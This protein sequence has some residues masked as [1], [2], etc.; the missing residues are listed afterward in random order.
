MATSLIKLYQRF[1]ALKASLH[2]KRMRRGG[3]IYMHGTSVSQD[4]L[5]GTLD[6]IGFSMARIAI[7]RLQSNND[8][9]SCILAQ[10]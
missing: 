3:A 5:F 9:H 10:R 2:R 1:A 4:W 8:A 7:I 6:S